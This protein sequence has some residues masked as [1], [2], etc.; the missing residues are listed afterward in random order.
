[1]NE[2][3]YVNLANMLGVEL[4]E[5]FHIDNNKDYTYVFFECGLFL[6]TN[7]NERSK[8][9]SLD[10]LQP[11]FDG[12]SKIT[13]IGYW[14]PKCGNHYFLPD[15]LNDDLFIGYGWEGIRFDNKVFNRN[16]VFRTKEEA[17]EFSRWLLDKIAEVR[18]DESWRND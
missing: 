16:L 13:S 18:V 1:M 11:V 10:V 17:V 8:R 4:G 3:Y 15:L 9:L 14:K 5:H 12:E 7:T 2:N 6:V